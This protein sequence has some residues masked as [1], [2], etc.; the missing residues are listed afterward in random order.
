MT[1]TSAAPLPS[2]RLRLLEWWRDI[3]D[4]RSVMVGGVVT[5]LIVL[6]AVLGPV[7]WPIDP[8]GFSKETFRA[9]SLAHP[10]GTDDL[11]RDVFARVIL[12][13]RISLTVGLVS[14]AIATLFGSLVGALSG[15]FGGRIDEAVMRFTELFQIIPR[16]LLAIVVVALFGSGIVKLVLVIGLLSWPGTARIVRA[17]FLV[18]RSEEFVLAATMSGA[19]PLR[20]ILRHI[21]PNILAFI[22]V[23]AFLQTGNAIL[24]E[25]FLSFLGLGDPAQPSWGLLLQQSQLYLR[26][27]W[28]MS[29]FPGLALA[30]TIFGINLLGDGIGGVQ[31]VSRRT[32]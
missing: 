4:N 7:L 18:L 14:G 29:V 9:P 26:S 17:Q 25:S 32:R 27:A 19:R 20:I 11:G 22:A 24:V 3:R 30:L 2:G 21:V 16:F 6:L 1:T 8:L 28:W 13:A 5:G 23:S 15:Y 31:A 10:M 12:G